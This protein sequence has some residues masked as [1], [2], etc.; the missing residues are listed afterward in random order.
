MLYLDTETHR[1]AQ[2]L[3]APRVVCVT[4]AINGRSGILHGRDPGTL[5]FMRS[6]LEETTIAG[7]HVSYDMACA[8]A[9][10]PELIPLV[11]AAYDADRIQCLMARAQLADIATGEFDGIRRGIGYSLAAQVK[12][13]LGETLAKDE[14]RL[15]YGELE[16]FALSDWPEGAIRY[17]MLD[18]EILERLAPKIPESPDLPFLP[19]F[20]L[21][22]YKSSMVFTHT[23]NRAQQKHHNEGFVP[24]EKKFWK[25]SGREV[26]GERFIVDHKTVLPS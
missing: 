19:E 15:G 2:G 20:F 12:R 5:G 17:A 10:W 1:H 24:T 25:K 14:W 11:F 23:F 22:R 8:C 18:A 21:S 13:R 9:T 7:W 3:K 6:A 26:G 4:W 16:A